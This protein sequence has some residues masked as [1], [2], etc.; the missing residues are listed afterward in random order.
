MKSHVVE[1]WI[2]LADLV[3]ALGIVGTVLL[4]GRVDLVVLVGFGSVVL[5]GRVDLDL[6]SVLVIAAA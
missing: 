1:D 3:E 6:D 4:V 5:V 2:A